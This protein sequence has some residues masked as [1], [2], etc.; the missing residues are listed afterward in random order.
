LIRFVPLPG[1]PCELSPAKECPPGD[2][3]IAFVPADAFAYAHLNL[4]RES[5]QYEDAAE[6]AARFPNFETIAQGLFGALGPAGRLD[7]AD[8]VFAWLGDEAA[9]AQLADSGGRPMPLLAL[10]VADQVG[11]RSF[12]AEVGGEASGA[13][14]YRGVDVTSYDRGL[15]SAESDGFLLFGAQAAVRAAID[16]GEG[17]TESL[18]DDDRAEAVRGT[19]PEDRLADVFVSRDGI[20]VL[21]AGRGGV[22]DQLDTFTDFD[23][24]EGI[25][26]ALTAED[27]GLGVEL[28]SELDPD[29]AEAAPSFFSAFPQFEPSL[30]SQFAAD[31]LA[32]LDAGE[33]SRTVGALLEQAQATFPGIADA[34]D[35][36]DARL[37]EA[38]GVEIERDLL[39]LLKGEAA[40]GVTPARPVPY[41][42]AVFDEVDEQRAREVVARLQAPLVTAF[43][44]LATGQAATFSSSEVEGVEIRGV[45]LSAGLEPSYAVFDDRLVVATDPAGV[46]QAIEGS[47]DLA[48]SEDYQ[49]AT[50]PVGGEVSALV[51]LNLAGLVRL[52][53]PR[54]LA[55]IVSAFEEDLARLRAL[56]LSVES[57]GDRLQTSL[58]L[59]IE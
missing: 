34:V 51:F 29:A 6:L 55:E 8:D 9:A 58:F 16:A 46:E 44:P 57:G 56:G 23:A 27:G 1:L 18:E 25:A 30:A 45:R 21:L 7:L 14:A 52:A 35:R 48:E 38:G 47:D 31:T 20:G 36:L 28:I 3:A 24:S 43:D 12:L 50:G 54:G 4:D 5:D 37:S 59:H 49:D 10:A 41:L 53:E 2:E 33:P 26:A 19:L 11:A 40:V 42:T 22:A 17:E 13:R 32:L 15:A 39:P